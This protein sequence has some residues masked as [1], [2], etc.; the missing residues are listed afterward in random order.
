[1]DAEDYG[2]AAAVLSDSSAAR[3]MAT[4]LPIMN[5]QRGV[6]A[7]RGEFALDIENKR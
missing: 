2:H 1:V 5:G 4:S 7:R 6:A 3:T